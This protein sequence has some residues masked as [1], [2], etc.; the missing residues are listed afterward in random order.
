[1][2]K[3]LNIFLALQVFAFIIGLLFILRRRQ[4]GH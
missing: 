1:M 4:P 2:P 3:L